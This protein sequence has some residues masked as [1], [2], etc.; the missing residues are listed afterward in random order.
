MKETNEALQIV[1]QH[2]VEHVLYC[3]GIKGN[4]LDRL[5]REDPEMH[6]RILSVRRAM[7]RQLARNTY[8]VS[9]ED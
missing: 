5:K 7:S 4:D 1:R 2:G 9:R 8:N 6:Q 3:L